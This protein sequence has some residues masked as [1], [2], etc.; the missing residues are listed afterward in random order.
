MMVF[1]TAAIPDLDIDYA[2]TY[3]MSAGPEIMM[4]NI[5]KEFIKVVYQKSKSIKKFSSCDRCQLALI[6]NAV[7]LLTLAEM[8]DIVHFAEAGRLDEF[9]EVDIAFI[10]GSINTKYDIHPIRKN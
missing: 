10:E 5:A 6:N 8:V 9:A 4:K 3:V 7:S 1:V 2:N